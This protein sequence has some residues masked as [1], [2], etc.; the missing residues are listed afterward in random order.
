MKISDKLLKLS[1]E[2]EKE[3]ESIFKEIDDMCLKN[4]IKVLDSFQKFNVNTSDFNEVIGYGYS[5]SGRD[6][7]ESIYSD[8]FG[9]EDA[10]VR[11]QIMNGTHAITLVL[12]ALLDPGDILI[13]IS[14]EPY[15]TIRSV[16]GIE[17][18]INNSLIKKGIKYEEIKYL[19]DFSYDEIRN[20]L[21]KNDV[22]MVEIQRSV[23][24]S[25]RESICISKIKKVIEEIRKV[26]KDVIIFVDNCYGEFVEDVEPTEVGADIMASSLMKNL[27]AGIATSGGYIAGRKDLIRLVADELNVIGVNKEMGANF[28]VLRS[29]YKGL[30]SAPSVVSSSLKTMIY[31][32]Y[33]L[34]KLGYKVIPSYDK[35]RTDIIQVI[36]FGNEKDLISFCQGIQKGGA[37]ESNLTLEPVDM[38]GY[39]H[40]EIMAGP[41]FTPGSTIE[42]SCDGPVIAPYKAFM[43]GSSTYEYGKLAILIAL[44]NM[45]N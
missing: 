35:K 34:E 31:A 1:N 16:I 13:S 17:G 3:L 19:D 27:G 39:P 38:P 7:L 41:S 44:T 2:A 40:K 43:Q 30:Y 6:K 33:M 23:G 22:K 29:Y 11:P 42:I 9:C 37:I 14:G 12:K 28:N 32:S 25:N 21:S 8:I 18:D 15:D 26:N 36:E 4:S 10:L 45:E 24:Y 20:R 5:D